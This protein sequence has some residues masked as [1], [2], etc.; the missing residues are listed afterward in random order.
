M[1]IKKLFYIAI[2]GSVLC[3]CGD[4]LLGCFYPVKKVGMFHLFLAFSEE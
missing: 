4:L 3:F 2:A 1:T